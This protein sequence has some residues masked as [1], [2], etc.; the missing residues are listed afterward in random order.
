[1]KA[2]RERPGPPA[3]T[4][5]S[6]SSVR[7]GAP[8]CPNRHNA[9]MYTLLPG[10][11]VLVPDAPALA[12]AAASALPADPAPSPGPGAPS[13]SLDPLGVPPPLGPGARGEGDPLLESHSPGEVPAAR[14]LGRPGRAGWWAWPLSGRWP[15]SDARSRPALG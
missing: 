2:A 12:L 10:L 5:W 9:T 8:R 14:G 3:Y 13:R 7:A 6:P 1:M 11:P 4:A 15:D